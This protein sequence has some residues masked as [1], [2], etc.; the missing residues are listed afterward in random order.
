V[1][2]QPSAEALSVTRAAGRSLPPGL[3]FLLLQMFSAA[4]WLMLAEPLLAGL[5]MYLPPWLQA[6]GTGLIAAALGHAWGLPI[7]WLPINFLFVAGLLA[8]QGLQLDAYWYLA[9]LVLLLLVYGRVALTRVPLYL[10][11]R[12][13]WQAVADLMPAR[14]VVADLGSGMGGLLAFLS[15]QRP[16]GV[17]VGVETAPLPFLISRLRA[18]LGGGRYSVGWN[19]FWKLDL[20]PYDVVYAYLSPVPMADLWRK[21][22]SEMRPGTLFISNTFAVPDVEASGMIQLDDLH[23]ST[24]YL[25]RL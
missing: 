16:E 4:L 5:G 18:R 9:A 20:Q 24:L 17:Y 23:H 7:W 21:A 11:S 12:A 19:N 13:A 10:S 2:P 15:R 1:Q 25:Y 8:M 3:K 22:R 14:A 6:L